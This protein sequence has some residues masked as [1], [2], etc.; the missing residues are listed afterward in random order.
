MMPDGNNKMAKPIAISSATPTPRSSTTLVS[1]LRQL[2]PIRT[3]SQAQ[4]FACHAWHDLSEENSDRGYGSD[5]STR[6]PHVERQEGFNMLRQR[7][8]TSESET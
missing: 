4:P 2:Q 5:G 3:R 8:A 6:H 1:A 7:M